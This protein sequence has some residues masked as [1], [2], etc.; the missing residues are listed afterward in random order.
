M[1]NWARGDRVPVAASSATD[2]SEEWSR[3]SYSISTSGQRVDLDTIHDF[4][5]AAYW[6]RGIPREI[7]ARSI[8]HSL[9]FGLYHLDTQV[10]FARVVTDRATFAYVCDV[11]VLPDHRGLGLGRWLMETVMRYHALQGLR[12]WVLLTRD[13]HN[14]YRTVGFDTLA[15]PDRYMERAD[16]DIYRSQGPANDQ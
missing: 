13:A 15:S 10:G 4:L 16:P 9:V 12:R 1:G 11:F 2:T 8:E 7:V 3:G 6:C 5:Q 14:L